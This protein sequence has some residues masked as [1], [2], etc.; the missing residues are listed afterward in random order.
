MD[1]FTLMAKIGLDSSEYDKGLNDSK[2]KLGSFA[3]NVGSTVS[4]IGSTI[5]NGIKKVAEVGSAMIG[6]ASGAVSAIGTAAVKNYAEYE[7]LVGGVDKLYGEASEKIQQYAEAAYKTSGMSANAY[8]ETATSFSA[9]LIGS[10]EG[11]VDKAAEMTDMAMRAMSDNVNVFGSDFGSVQNAFQGFA[12]QNYT[13][14]DNLKLGYGGTKAEMERLISDANEYRESIGESADL[15]IDSF[16]DVVQ[17]IQSVQE[18]QN[19]AGTTNKEAMTTIE[20]SATATKAAWENVLTAIGRGEGIAEAIKGLT[21][22]IFGAEEGEGLLNQIIPRI[23]TVMQGVGNFVAQAGP[24]ISDKLPELI[25]SVLPT[26]VESGVTLLGA[27][28]TGLLDNID[29]ILDAAVQVI[30]IMSQ[31]FIDAFPTLLG[32]AGELGSTILEL[33]KSAAEAINNFDWAGTAKSIA[34][35]LKEAITGEGMQD[36]IAT[37]FEIIGG[38]AS[39]IGEALPELVPAAVDIILSLVDTLTNPDSIGNL[40]DGAL[41]MI[42][43]LADGLILA[44][45]VLLKKAPEIIINLV[46]ALVDNIPKLIQAAGELIISVAGA[47]TDP[48]NLLLIVKG[49]WEIIAAIVQGIAEMAFKLPQV[50]L[51]LITSFI[52]AIGQ[53]FSS[54][55]DVG[56]DI[57][58]FVKNGIKEKIDDAVNWGRDL[59]DN[60]MGGIREKW[61]NLKS[62]ISDIAGTVRDFLGFSEPKEGPL[63]N[64]HTYAPDMMELFAKGIKDNE[65]LVTDQLQKS[66]DFSDVLADQNINMGASGA[67]ANSNVSYGGININVYGAEGQN[68]N[69]LADAVSY[70]LAHLMN[71]TGAVY[72]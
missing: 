23:E 62:T 20:G 28:G 34:E 16:A 32:I 14:L 38:I 54:L 27:L 29:V 50:A 42:T 4:G 47:L 31:A 64:F 68:I 18:A 36:F 25:D 10:L 53:K 33:M 7:Q 66:F 43:G 44:L 46:Q 65:G 63:S 39:G 71:R 45:P 59:I 30:E 58:D 51:E 24:F 2:S 72:A 60:F 19:I 26:V 5:G 41:S 61:E 67:G 55:R 8:M 3:D 11:D 6:V 70:R 15:S 48:K 21:D 69:E 49:A 57:I 1:A 40:V 37:A 17:A 12:K 9:A 22:S 52:D 56:N 13:M 35:F